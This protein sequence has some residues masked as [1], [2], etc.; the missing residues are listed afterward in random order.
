[1]KISEYIVS[2]LREIVA[3]YD[4]KHSPKQLFMCVEPAYRNSCR[5]SKCKIPTNEPQCPRIPG[6]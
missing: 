4:D 1:M 6:Q 2:K 3:R 5:N